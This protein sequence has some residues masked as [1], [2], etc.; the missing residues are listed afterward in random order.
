M[1]KTDILSDC[2]AKKALCDK[3]YTLTP[4]KNLAELQ[5]LLFNDLR[6]DEQDFA[7]L[8]KASIAELPPL[9]H[10]TNLK[11]LNKLIKKNKYSN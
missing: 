7:K 9:Y 3:L 8:D 1:K 2:N 5:A 6:I 11:L 10:A 4:T